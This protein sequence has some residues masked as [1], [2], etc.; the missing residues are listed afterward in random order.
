M[1][2]GTGAGHQKG[3]CGRIHHLAKVCGAVLQYGVVTPNKERGW[4][5][6]GG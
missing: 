5:I 1:E 4:A 3:F 2:K 6:Q